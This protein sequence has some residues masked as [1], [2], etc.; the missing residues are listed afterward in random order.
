[1]QDFESLAEKAKRA[2]MDLSNCAQEKEAKLHAAFQ[3][4]LVFESKIKELKNRVE[5][6]EDELR[7]LRMKK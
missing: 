1:M 6:L 2:V 3:E 5:L 4:K 7:E